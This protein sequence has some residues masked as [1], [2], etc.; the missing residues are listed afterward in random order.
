MR[1]LLATLLCCASLTSLPATAASPNRAIAIGLPSDARATLDALVDDAIRAHDLPGGVLVVTSGEKVLYRKAY[2]VRT[3]EPHPVTNDPSTIYEFAS[4]TKPMATASAIMLLVQRGVLRLGDKV[5]RWIP[6]Y[7]QNGKQDVTIQELLTQTSG[8]QID[9]TRADFQSDK[10]TILAHLDATALRFAPGTKFEY[11]DLAF[12]TLAD[13]VTH[14]AGMPYERFVQD[15]IFRPLGMRDAFFDTTIDPTH[16][17][18]LAPQI[19]A[20]TVQRLRDAYGTVPGLNGHAGMLAT[21]DDVALLARAYLRAARGE[22]SRGFA[23]TPATVRAMIEPHYV[24]NG[25]VRGLG[26][27]LDS[28]YSR[29]RGEIFARGGFGHTGSSG[30]SV[31]IDPASDLAYVF[32]TNA[33]YPDDHGTT[34]YLEAKLATVIAANAEYRPDARNPIDAEEEQSAR[35]SA[36]AARSALGFPAT[37]GPA[38]TPQPSA[39]HGP[40]SP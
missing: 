37:P 13:V 23:L 30:T 2:G 24:G 36:D 15:Q 29:N 20:Q 12:I 10:A 39:S 11:S 25:A 6:A 40:L 34:L 35:F 14:A 26:W 33:H 28:A 22:E 1:R 31:W 38:P 4:M 27:D 7:A 16:A 21:A 3:L 5:A 9:Y 32:A 19:R 17:A 18:R 8:M